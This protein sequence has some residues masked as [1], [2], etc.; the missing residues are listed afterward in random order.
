MATNR[1]H[2]DGTHLYLPVAS[3]VESGDP[4]MVGSLPGV[5]LIDRDDNDSATVQT[6]GVYNL[7]VHAHDGSAG[8]AISVG[9]VVYFDGTTINVDSSE[10]RFG[11]AL[12]AITSGSTETI[13]VKVG[14]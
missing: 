11:Y 8:A 4:V 14:Y 3:G 2:K 12:D 1:E 5:A 10:S 9:D 6:N 7:A 13:R